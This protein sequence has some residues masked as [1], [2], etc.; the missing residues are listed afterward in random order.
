MYTLTLVTVNGSN[1]IVTDILITSNAF[2]FTLC[3]HVH[4]NILNVNTEIVVYSLYMHF[5]CNIIVS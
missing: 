1:D 5:T 3:D 4:N 2:Q